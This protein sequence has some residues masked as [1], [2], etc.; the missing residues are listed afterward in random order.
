MHE[1]GMPAG[2]YNVVH[3]FGPDSAGQALVQHPDVA[4]ITFTGESANSQRIMADA[5]PTLK[6][7]SSEPGETQLL[8]LPMPTLTQRW[9]APYVRRSQTVDKSA[10]VQSVSTL[11]VLSLIGLLRL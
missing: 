3:G 1:I 11:S 6:P 10:C 4:A 7:L 2:V 8:S 5:S 9:L